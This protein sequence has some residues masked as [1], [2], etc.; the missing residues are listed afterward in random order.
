M[1]ENA[2][3]INLQY[4]GQIA[5]ESFQLYGLE[6]PDNTQDVFSNLLSLDTVTSNDTSINVGLV[7]KATE[8]VTQIIN[9]PFTHAL[10]GTLWLYPSAVSCNMRPSQPSSVVSTYRASY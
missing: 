8:Y 7:D 9:E 10:S 5:A 6:V 4:L 3:L 1:T 2:D